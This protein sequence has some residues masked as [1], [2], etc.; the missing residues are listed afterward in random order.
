MPTEPSLGQLKYQHSTLEVSQQCCSL[1][2]HHWAQ[3]GTLLVLLSPTGCQGAHSSRSRASLLSHHP[4]HVETHM[5]A[6]NH[7]KKNI[8]FIL[9]SLRSSSTLAHW[10]VCVKIR[11]VLSITVIQD[12]FKNSGTLSSNEQGLVLSHD[13][14]SFQLAM[15]ESLP[16]A[17]RTGKQV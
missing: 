15:E 14:I 5:L 11:E 17:S 13:E 9:S 3:P 6:G 8:L 12:H 10:N 1:E 4:D 16:M 7:C 2:K